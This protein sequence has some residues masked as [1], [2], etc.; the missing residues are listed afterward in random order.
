MLVRLDYRVGRN[1]SLVTTL[2]DEGS[3]IID[4]LWQYRY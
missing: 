1:W 2:G 4:F 3:S